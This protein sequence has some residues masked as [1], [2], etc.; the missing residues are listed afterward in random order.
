MLRH[1]EFLGLSEKRILLIIVAP[2]G[3][4]QNRILVTDRPYSPS[5]L[6]E[7]ANFLNQNYAG[8]DSRNL[9]RRCATN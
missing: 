5:E 3:D 4:V 2:D 9:R 7:A 6:T 1:I 8:L